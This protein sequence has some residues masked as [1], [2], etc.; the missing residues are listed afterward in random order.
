VGGIAFGRSVFYMFLSGCQMKPEPYGKPME[1]TQFRTL[2]Y[3]THE[4]N[5]QSIS[6]HIQ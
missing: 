4:Y 2:A 6:S 3:T 1:C 5:V